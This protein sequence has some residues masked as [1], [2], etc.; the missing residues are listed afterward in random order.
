[1][2]P[3]HRPRWSRIR[4]PAEHR[5][6]Q[7]ATLPQRLRPRAVVRERPRQ[8]RMGGAKLSAPDGPPAW[9]TGI[10]V[11][12]VDRSAARARR[13]PLGAEPQRSP[14]RQQRRR[15]DLSPAM[16]GSRRCV[17]KTRYVPMSKGG[18][19]VAR[20]HL[21]D[22]RARPRTE[23]EL[24]LQR[25]RDVGAERLTTID[26]RL[27]E[28]LSWERTIDMRAIAKAANLERPHALARLDTL[29]GLQLVERTSATS[30]RFAEGW[31]E[32]LRQRCERA[33]SS[34]GCIE[35]YRVEPSRIGSLS[36][37]KELP[38]RA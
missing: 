26:R 25:S 1:L 27:A 4:R 21:G 32:T 22:A 38:S 19:K 7:P 9:R 15:H 11:A 13:E 17:V 18:A 34:S 2:N 35:R 20:A 10:D 5:R 16:A 31:Q 30:W 6:P 14:T 28:H 23:D 8:G 12:A 3:A 37:A 24:Q 29:E 33:T 36:T